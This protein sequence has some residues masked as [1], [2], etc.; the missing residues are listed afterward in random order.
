MNVKVKEKYNYHLAARPDLFGKGPYRGV[1]SD[2]G[3][4]FPSQQALLLAHAH[5]GSLWPQRHIQ[6]NPNERRKSVF[7]APVKS[8]LFSTLDTFW[9]GSSPTTTAWSSWST[10]T[11]SPRT[12]WTTLSYRTLEFR[13]NIWKSPSSSLTTPSRS[14]HSGYVRP[15]LWTQVREAISVFI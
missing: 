5:L 4:L 1:H 3:L 10:P 6:V 7:L 12:S 15:G 11:W 2:L 14:I 8:N 13:P 9:A